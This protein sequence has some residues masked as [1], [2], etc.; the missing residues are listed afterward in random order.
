[1]TDILHSTKLEIWLHK[2]VGKN[3]VLL[4]SYADKAG[5]RLPITQ[6]EQAERLLKLLNKAARKKVYVDDTAYKRYRDAKYAYEAIKF[7]RWIK[8]GH[9]IEPDRPTEDT[10]GLT[11]FI[12]DFL[13]WEGHFANRTGNEGRVLKDGTRIPSSSKKGMQDVDSNLKHSA[14]QFGI[15]WKIEVKAGKDTHKQHQKDYGALVAKT[16]G[17]YSVVHNATDLLQQYDSLMVGNCKQSSIFV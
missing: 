17:V 12:V 3:P 15:P 8:D 7:P 13:T 1:M 2:K 9:F 10:N 11:G 4:Q 14:H 6:V 5:V 16:G